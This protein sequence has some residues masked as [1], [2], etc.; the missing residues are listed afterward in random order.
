MLESRTGLIQKYR[1]KSNA[2]GNCR[3]IACKL[4]SGIVTNKLYEYLKNQEI[5]PQEKNGCRR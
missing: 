2:V 4:L 1:T 3:P 5:S